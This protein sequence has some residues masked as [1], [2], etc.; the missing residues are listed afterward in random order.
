MAIINII[1]TMM[2]TFNTP[3]G[4]YTPFGRARGFLYLGFALSIAAGTYCFA[5]YTN[6]KK[7]YDAV[8]DRLRLAPEKL[9][10]EGTHYVNLDCMVYPWASDLRSW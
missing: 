1:D 2:E 7:Y 5:K 10:D 3:H 9:Q 8:R 4:G 6:E